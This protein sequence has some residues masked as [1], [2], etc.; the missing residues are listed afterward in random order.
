VTAPLIWYAEGWENTAAAAIY[1][2]AGG[3]IIST[4]LWRATI[5][6]GLVEDISA[7]PYQ[8]G[9]V[10]LNIDNAIKTSA[11]FSVRN[12]ED[13]TP[14]SD[15]LAPFITFQYQ[16]GRPDVTQQLG[17]F[18]TTLAPGTK[19]KEDAAST[20]D[21]SDMTIVASD[22]AMT[23]T[24]NVAAGTN[25]VTAVLSLL[26]SAGITRT[27]I[28]STSRTV[29]VDTSFPIGTSKLAAANQLLM[30]IGWYELG[31]DLDGRVST[32]GATRDLSIMHP[33]STLTVDDLLSPVEEQPTVTSIANVVIVKS[34]DST[35]APIKSVARN[36]DPSSPTSTVAIGRK[37]VQTFTLSG[38]VT[39]AD[40]DAYAAR[41]LQQG[42]SYYQTI[43]FKTW[44]DP[45]VLRPHQVVD[46][47]LT[48]RLEPL[49]GRY[50]VRT[51]RVGFTPDTFHPQLECNR[52]TD[53]YLGRVI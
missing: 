52:V 28:P 31:M 8:G 53:A 16:D 34:D 18:G 1:A 22:D 2:T 21:G 41:Q 43:K 14:Y 32:P 17:L 26:T 7:D 50:W 11:Q 33:Y 35:V 42:R 45:A 36:D 15:Y 46:L 6:N 47:N 27:N 12:P 19:T 10:D 44:F 25:V 29:S 40:L 4:A 49:N 51:A 30:N 23:D 48:G 37:I 5:T 20:F 38:K 9:Y 39:Q 3:G 24:T 13:I